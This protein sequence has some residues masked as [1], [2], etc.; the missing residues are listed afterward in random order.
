M[1]SL[2]VIRLNLERSSDCNYSKNVTILK[3]T[4][5]TRLRSLFRKLL[6]IPNKDLQSVTTSIK[7]NHSKKR[8]IIKNFQPK[9]H[10]INLTLHPS[11]FA[12]KYRQ[13]VNKNPQNV[14]KDYTLKHYILYIGM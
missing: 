10:P 9:L 3:K 2:F 11:N 5:L 12:L 7:P 6:D 4:E 1:I 8:L 14:K 13:S